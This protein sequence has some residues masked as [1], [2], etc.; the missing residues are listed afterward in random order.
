MDCHLYT[1]VYTQI[2]SNI[3]I[4]TAKTLAVITTVHTKYNQTPV[5]SS[6]TGKD[7]CRQCRVSPTGELTNHERW[8]HRI[9]Q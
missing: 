6:G 9:K 1:T 5:I 3:I 4:T 2:D 7:T 8:R